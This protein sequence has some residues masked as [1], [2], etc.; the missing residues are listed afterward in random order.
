ML[1][2][3]LAQL[4]LKI[5]MFDL[6]MYLSFEIWLMNFNLLPIILVP[7]DKLPGK[8]VFGSPV[9]SV[10]RTSGGIAYAEYGSAIFLVF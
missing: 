9:Q 1:K 2:Y 5:P 4:S 7:L 10:S 8:V 3:Y 6:Q